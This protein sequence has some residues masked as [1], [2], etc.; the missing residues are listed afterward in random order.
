MNNL[1]MLDCS[2]HSIKSVVMLAH[3]VAAGNSWSSP[4]GGW[5]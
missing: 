3:E 1:K 5:R 4:L 2:L